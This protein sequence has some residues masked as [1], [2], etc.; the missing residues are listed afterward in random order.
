LAF[1]ALMAC[2]CP[3]LSAVALSPTAAT[4]DPATNE[5][6]ALLLL[7]E[8]QAESVDT[9]DTI[10]T[11]T[12]MAQGLTRTLKTRMLMDK[13]HGRMKMQHFG[14]SG[15]VTAEFLVEGGTVYVRGPMKPTWTA[16]PMDA[17][18]QASLEAQGIAPGT[19]GKGGLAG[20][21]KSD[22]AALQAA[23]QPAALDAAEP[24]SGTPEAELGLLRHRGWNRSQMARADQRIRRRLLARKARLTFD[25]VAGA[26]DAARG[27]KAL[28]QRHDAGNPNRP[29]DEELLKLDANGQV[30]E[31]TQFLRQ[32][33]WPGGQTKLPKQ[34]R[35]WDQVAPGVPTDITDSPLVELGHSVVL[36]SHAAR[37]A[38][39]QD[40]TESVSHTGDGPVTMHTQWQY[41]HVNE[42]VDPAEFD[43]NR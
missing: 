29:Y 1:A 25:R 38:V 16:L 41:N 5:A 36:R 14:D 35:R 40:E 43:R 20:L 39:V 11:T 12:V 27:L 32:S 2:V 33:R 17:Q 15:E 30:V 10:S 6:D 7:Q 26:D 34:A 21:E 42:A 8:Q 22:G 23:S 9:L 37:G 4:L 18:T 13:P 28:R 19:T 3:S 24:A 31:R